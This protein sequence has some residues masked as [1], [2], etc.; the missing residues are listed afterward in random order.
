[1]K[2][3]LFWSI[4][5]FP[6]D[7][8]AV[9]DVSS[10]TRITTL[11]L[12]IARQ[13][14]ATSNRLSTA[15]FNVVGIIVCT[16]ILMYS[17]YRAYTLWYEHLQSKLET[18]IMLRVLDIQREGT[19]ISFHLELHNLTEAFFDILTWLIVL[20]PRISKGWQKSRASSCKTSQQ[21]FCQQLEGNF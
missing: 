2:Q 12:K 18:K 21:R 10:E 17:T 16:L 14:Q 4:N 11:L 19:P 8:F 5:R 15:M 3:L 13:S 1:M 9:W 7:Q 20:K 6:K